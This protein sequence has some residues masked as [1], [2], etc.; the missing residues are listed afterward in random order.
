MPRPF[1]SSTDI[2]KP[3]IDFCV[4][5]YPS[6][7]T[8]VYATKHPKLS[9]QEAAKEDQWR[10]ETLPGSLKA[11]HGL[12]K[13]QLARLVRW[14][15]THGISRPFLPSMI[16]KNSEAEVQQ[17]TAHAS[18]LLSNLK[19]SSNRYKA[20]GAALD[21][22]CKL[23][24]VG[25]ATGTLVLSIYDPRHVPF[26][27]DEVFA[28]VVDRGGNEGWSDQR[29]EVKNL[30]LKY[31]RK[32]YAAL[33]EGVSKVVKGV[34]EV[35]AQEI[36]KTAYVLM[37]ADVLSEDERVEL[38]SLVMGKTKVERPD[39]VAVEAD[40]TAETKR[41]GKNGHEADGSTAEEIDPK[42]PKEVTSGKSVSRQSQGRKRKAQT[43]DN[44]EPGPGLRRS[45]RAKMRKNFKSLYN[46]GKHA[47]D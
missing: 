15:I 23:K 16:Q 31:D 30:K 24:G 36:E 14:K 11:G 33:W 46:A 25:P 42:G 28:W 40:G 34:G 9:A 18:T 22:V 8:R 32:E 4:T 12:G 44:L 45:K 35:T 19:D 21:E 10:Y 7:L 20:V 5:K 29:F 43:T 17:H 38:E 39:Q 27:A 2:S 26:F 47:F 41:L 1:I 6:V 37:Y 3:A 13:D